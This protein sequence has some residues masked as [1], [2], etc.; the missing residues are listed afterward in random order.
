MPSQ[1]AR[2]TSRDFPRKNIGVLPENELFA[3]IFRSPNSKT[4]VYMATDKKDN[5]KI[6]VTNRRA[7]FEYNFL[8]EYEAGI[9]L[10]G[11][12]IKS[13]RQ[14]NVNL[15]DAYCLFEGN[16]L[17]VRNLYIKE[18]EFGTDNNHEARR[19]RKL[20]LRK[21]E[22]KK[23]DRKVREKGN[24]IVPYKL[25][26]NERGF[27]KLTIELA[28]GKKT[29]DKRESIKERDEKRDLDRLKKIHK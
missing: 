23:L 29:F 1:I 4:Y 12:E 22:L 7:S 9:A 26:I 21:S 25:H 14:G 3:F 20:L 24:T 16:E 17:F 2:A 15:S 6:E 19:T 27:A 5:R 28:T 10:T 18:Y 8:Q 11:T 13:I